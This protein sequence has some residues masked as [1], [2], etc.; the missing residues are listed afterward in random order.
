MR[1]EL[2]IKEVVAKIDKTLHQ[3]DRII[4]KAT[5]MAINRTIRAT[6]ASVT[7]AIADETGYKPRM[8]RDNIKVKLSKV[9]TLTGYVEAPRRPAA[10]N[11]IEFVRR[12]RQT[13]AF[14]RRR[15]KSNSR[16]RG[17]RKGQYKFKGVE[18]SAWNEV[19][20]YKGTFIGRDGRGQ[21]KV[22]RRTAGPRSRPTLVSGPS[23]P[24]TFSDGIMMRYMEREAKRRF[25]I[26]F[27]RAAKHL[28]R[29]QKYKTIIMPT[30]FFG[31]FLV[32]ISL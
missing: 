19:K 24:A 8:V 17:Y 3:Y 1:L 16:Q 15:Y 14:F 26:E 13:P 25:V 31:P 11:L 30:I 18:A 22:F 2:N 28:I 9:S 32:K 12:N 27:E 6:K 29:Q 10:I 20:T 21:M 7:K 5:S 4:T 23:I